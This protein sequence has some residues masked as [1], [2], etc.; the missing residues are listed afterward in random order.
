M[1]RPGKQFSSKTGNER[2]NITNFFTV[3]MYIYTPIANTNI[4]S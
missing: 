4:I 1:S 2:D 3:F